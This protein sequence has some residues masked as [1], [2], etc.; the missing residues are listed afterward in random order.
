MYYEKGCFFLLGH[1]L[2]QTAQLIPGSRRKTANQTIPM[3]FSNQN[4]R[5]TSE[6]Q[7]CSVQ[8]GTKSLFTNK[9]KCSYK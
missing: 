2:V 7:P 1:S 3:L 5:K 4:S 9:L 6:N 8:Q